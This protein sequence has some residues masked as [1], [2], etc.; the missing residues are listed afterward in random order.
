[1]VRMMKMMMMMIMVMI[2]VSMMIVMMSE[3]QVA[4][5]VSVEKVKNKPVSLVVHCCESMKNKDTKKINF[6]NSS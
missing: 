3:V 5:M 6:S 4:R 1:M 2:M